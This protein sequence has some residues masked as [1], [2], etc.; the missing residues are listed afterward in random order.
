MDASEE[1][2]KILL[3]LLPG[4]IFIKIVQ[5]RCSLK[6]YEPY[7]YIVDSLIA[8]LIIYTIASGFSITPNN[9]TW[10]SITII[11]IIT[12]VLA[13][14]WSLVLQ[15]DL[16]SKILH[17]G[18]TSISTHHSI[19][20]V[21]AIE[22]FKRKWH[23]VRLSDGKEIVGIVREFNYDTKEMLIEKGRMILDEGKT[24][25]DSAWYYIPSGDQVI[26]IRTIEKN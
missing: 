16:L 13:I 25:E 20:P 3:F 7:Q 1:T 12:I 22:K 6:K 9:S 11:I 23:L 24:S 18:E 15:K 19:Y 17:P 2:V 26:Y 14:I 10:Q 8:S 5:L 21:K 4:F